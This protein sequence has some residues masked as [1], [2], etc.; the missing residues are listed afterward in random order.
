M[1]YSLCKGGVGVETTVA[2]YSLLGVK[3]IICGGVRVRMLFKTRPLNLI[4]IN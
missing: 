3:G 1:S 2:V 4:R